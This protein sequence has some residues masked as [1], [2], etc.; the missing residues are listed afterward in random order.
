MKNILLL[1]TCYLFQHGTAICQDPP[2]CHGPNSPFCYEFPDPL[3]GPN[4]Y[5]LSVCAG[6]EIQFEHKSQDGSWTYHW[7]SSPTDNSLHCNGQSDLTCHNPIAIPYRNT[8]YTVIGC[9]NGETDVVYKAQFVVSIG[10]SLVL[11]PKESDFLSGK[12]GRVMIST[13]QDD[14]YYTPYQEVDGVHGGDGKVKIKAFI[15][16]ANA[17]MGQTVYFRVRDPDPDDESSYEKATSGSPETG[18]DNLDPNNENGLLIAPNG[19]SGSVVNVPASMGSSDVINGV[20]AWIVQ[21]DLKITDQY[22]GDNYVVEASL[23][24]NFEPG[25]AYDKTIN[26]VAWKRIYVEY[27]RMY[28]KGATLI[29]D[30]T[31]DSDTNDDVLYV[32]NVDD[33]IVDNINPMQIQLFSVDGISLSNILV[34]NKNASLN[35]LT[36]SDIPYNSTIDKIRSGI[37]IP[38]DLSSYEIDK[39]QLVDGFGL[40]TSGTDGGTFVEFIFDIPNENNFAPCYKIFPFIITSSGTLDPTAIYVRYTNSWF[41]HAQSGDKTN[42][43][44]ALAGTEMA[45]N[46]STGFIPGGVTL[47]FYNTSTIFV[48]KN[49]FPTYERSALVHEFGHQF[50]VVSAHVDSDWPR[51]NHMD[52]DFC[53]MTYIRE[54]YNIAEFDYKQ[55]D[56]Y[57]CIKIIRG[58]HDGL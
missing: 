58:E 15:Y 7:T 32:D 21:V 54:H 53:I 18:G 45:A 34:K 22:S 28:K 35:S 44:L 24:P 49:N 31:P 57:S 29:Q 6:R 43:F 2:F 17:A 50:N 14:I 26:L 39:S 19:Q 40:N 13:Y 56:D 46:P 51:R 23:S 41:D 38:S 52:S 9:K 36:V 55:D 48:K 47:S 11:G 4:I 8:T 12:Q 42:V 16:P 33:F 37:R 10:L 5:N 27:D 3:S 30:F 1:L 20:S 25:C